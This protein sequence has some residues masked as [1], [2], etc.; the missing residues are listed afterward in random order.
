MHA[1]RSLKI[2]F[3]FWFGILLLANIFCLGNTQII[4]ADSL[5]NRS[6][7]IQQAFMSE[8]PRESVPSQV[9]DAVRQELSN[10]TRIAPNKFKVVETR[11]QIWS[12]GCLGLAKPDEICTQALVEGWRVVLSHGDRSWIYRTDA[13]GNAIRLETETEK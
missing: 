8:Q 7:T 3:R 11:Q 4:L 9:I 1:P 5:G 13:Q 12:D 10:R 6:G 2:R